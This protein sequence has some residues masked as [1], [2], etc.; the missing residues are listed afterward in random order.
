MSLLSWIFYSQTEYF[1]RGPFYKFSL[2]CALSYLIQRI[3]QK[4]SWEWL[5]I[6]RMGSGSEGANDFDIDTDLFIGKK[7]LSMLFK[8][9]L[10]AYYSLFAILSLL[11]YLKTQKCRK[12]IFCVSFSQRSLTEPQKWWTNNFTFVDLSGES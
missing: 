4:S 6:T 8:V 9:Q 11:R 5:V 3:P 10:H 2:F 7:L 12:I 1:S